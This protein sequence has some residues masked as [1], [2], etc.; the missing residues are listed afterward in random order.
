MINFNGAYKIKATAYKDVFRAC[1]LK[2]K[3]YNGNTQ[4]SR[5]EF[6]QQFTNGK[7]DFYGV[8][9]GDSGVESGDLNLNLRVEAE[10]IVTNTKGIILYSRT[11]NN[12]LQY[13][14][15][16]INPFAY[17][18]ED[19]LWRR[20]VPS[21]RVFVDAN[22]FN[23]FSVYG[24]LSPAT[25]LQLT[26]DF[27]RPPAFKRIVGINAWFLHRSFKGTEPL[28]PINTRSQIGVVGSGADAELKMLE[29]EEW[30]NDPLYYI[31]GGLW[32]NLISSSDY[33]YDSVDSDSYYR[34]SYILS[35][36][37]HQ[38][39]TSLITAPVGLPITYPED[40]LESR[41]LNYSYSID[42]DKSFSQL[43]SESFYTQNRTPL[44]KDCKTNALIY[45]EYTDESLKL[46]INNSLINEIS[47]GSEVEHYNTYSFVSL[48]EI[49]GYYPSGY[50]LYDNNYWDVFVSQKINNG[51]RHKN[52]TVTA[53]KN[54][55]YPLLFGQNPQSEYELK[56]DFPEEYMQAL[57]QVSIDPDETSIGIRHESDL[58]SEETKTYWRFCNA[59]ILP[60][61]L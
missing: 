55:Y 15:N 52:M 36:V 39:P 21:L 54:K 24:I 49:L 34:I 2:V 53:R 14:V 19:F 17:L 56:V 26:N 37:V 50:F 8:M 18:Y 60:D 27:F 29:G 9:F 4:L 58:Y 35:S 38:Y 6:A 30:F 28:L 20:L 46:W 40:P 3:F 10:V 13:F 5:N 61:Q 33:G 45:S 42:I 48:G 32:V 22:Q 59:I 23:D 11:F 57:N 12:L 44:I 7:T 1:F 31:G 47:Y 51:I 43:Q 16:E 25:S 41:D